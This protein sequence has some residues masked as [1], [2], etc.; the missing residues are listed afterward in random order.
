MDSLT[1]Q[2]SGKR[3]KISKEITKF[4]AQFTAETWILEDVEASIA[5]LELEESALRELDSAIQELSTVSDLEDEMVRC[6]EYTMKINKALSRLKAKKREIC[7]VDKKYVTP[8][9]G[10]SVKHPKLELPRFSGSWREWTHFWDGFRQVHESRILPD[11][12]KIRY[13]SSCL[14]GTAAQL[15][16]GI[17]LEDG[18]YGDMV[19][20]LMKT[21][22]R[23]TALKASHILA[24]VGLETPTNDLQALSEFRAQIEGH[25]RSLQIL[26]VTCDEILTCLSYKVAKCYGYY[27]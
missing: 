2:R 11:I 17:T 26:K 21:Y 3:G 12:D 16:S 22:G 8:D 27:T 6:N 9:V 10:H 15:V 18:H 19:E 7:D 24:L 25:V 1:K 5:L 13:L 4:D 23:P 14:E 20:L